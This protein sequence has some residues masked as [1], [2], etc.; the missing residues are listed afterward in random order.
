MT[1]T[2]NDLRKTYTDIQAKLKSLDFNTLWPGF[3]AFPFALYDEEFVYFEGN[4]IA[5]DDRFQ[6]NT[7]IQIDGEHIAIWNMRYLEYE[8]LNFLAY[9]LVHEMFHC[10]QYIQGETRY[11]NDLRLLHQPNDIVYFGMKKAEIETICRA[12]R[13]KDKEKEASFYL[14]AKMHKKRREMFPEIT[15]EEELAQSI[16]GTAEYVAMKALFHLSTEKY[17][18]QLERY[19]NLMADRKMLFS[20]RLLAYFNGTFMCL[21]AEE[22]DVQWD[23]T[24]SNQIHTNFDLIFPSIE[25]LDYEL[26]LTDNF[27]LLYKRHHGKILADIK[28][29]EENG[30]EVLLEQPAIIKYF[31]PMQMVRIEDKVYSEHF[32]TLED[33]HE[34]ITLEGEVVLC[35]LAESS[36]EVVSYTTIK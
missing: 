7:S 24:I 36:N 5:W 19:I 14:Y 28:N 1:I 21:L 9:N 4:T 2:T 22:L 8:E 10:F 27:N 29:V 17:Q 33:D 30:I 15:F 6:G 31:D 20:N 23:R 11:P 26:E 35:L 25:A 13:E 32:I 12:F 18:E 16:E 34:M 3:T